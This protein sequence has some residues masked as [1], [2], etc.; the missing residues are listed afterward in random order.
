VKARLAARVLPVTAIRSPI[1]RH[2]DI[3]QAA[4]V[5]RRPRLPETTSLHSLRGELVTL[6]RAAH[7][8]GYRPH[9]FFLHRHPHQFRPSFGN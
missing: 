2:E 9:A 8:S 6:A 1:N 5:R 4:G 3:A 7:H